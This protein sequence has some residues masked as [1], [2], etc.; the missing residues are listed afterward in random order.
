MIAQAVSGVE[1]DLAGIDSGGE[2][3]RGYRAPQQRRRLVE[4]RPEDR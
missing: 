2:L 3:G 1:L 4:R